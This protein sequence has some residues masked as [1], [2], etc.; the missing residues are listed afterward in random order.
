MDED[1]AFLAG[2]GGE[3]DGG[4]TLGAIAGEGDDLAEAVFGVLDEHA[5][6]EG[7]GGDWSLEAG[8]WR[9]GCGGFEL[10]GGG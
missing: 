7:V 4:G 10:S 3:G 8:G 2:A 9:L 1:E 5:V 6:M